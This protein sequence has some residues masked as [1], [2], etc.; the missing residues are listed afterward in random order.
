MLEK[1]EAADYPR[2]QLVRI[3]ATV[4]IVLIIGQFWTALPASRRPQVCFL[5][6]F[7]I[8]QQAYE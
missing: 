5:D 8:E 2:L 7:G 3:T 6:S 1:I 4:E